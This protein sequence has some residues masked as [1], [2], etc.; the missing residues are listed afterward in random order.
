MWRGGRR[1]AVATSRRL[2]NAPDT[3]LRDTSSHVDQG[4]ARAPHDLRLRRAG[5]G[6]PARRPPPPGAAQPHA[7]RGLLARRASRTTTSST[8]SRTPSATGWPGWS[9]PRRSPTLDITVGLV[10]DLMVINPFDFFVE[11]YAERCRSPT[12]TSL[13]ADLAPYL[14]PVDER[15]GPRRLRQ[16]LP[17][18]AGRPRRTARRTVDVP[19]R[20]QRRRARRVAYSVRMEPGRAD[21][22][23][24][25]H[26]RRSAPAATRPGCWSRC[27]ASTASPPASSP[28]TSCSSPPTRSPRR[29]Q[30]PGPRLH[31]PARLGRGL[32]ARCRLGRH[33][34]D[35]APLR[36][37]GPHPALRD[38]R[39]RA[40]PPRSRAPPSP[41]EVTFSFHN[42]VTRVHEDP[43]VTK[44]YTDDQWAR[45]DALGEAVDQRLADGD[46]RLTMGGEPTFVSLD[47]TD[48]RAVEHR[49][50]RPG[51]ARPWPP[52][53]PS[54]CARPT[55]R[56]G[57][58]T[59]ARASGTPASPCPAG[60]I[61]LQWRTDGVPL[62]RAR[63]SSPTRGARAATRRRPPATPRPSPP[64]SRS[65]LGLP[66][67][68]RPPGVRGP[69]RRR[70]PP[71][72]A[73]RRARPPTRTP[74]RST[75]HGLG[76]RWTR[77]QVA[78][79]H[80]LGAAARHQHGRPGRLGQ[81]AVAL[82]PRPARAGAGHRPAG[83]RLP[84]DSVAWKE[85]G[86]G[87]A[88]VP[89]GR[90]PRWSRRARR[91]A[92]STRGRGHHRAGVRGPRR[93]TSTSS[94]RP[95][96]Q[97]DDYAALLSS[98]SAAARTVGRP[99][100]LEGYGPP[101]DP[102]LTQLIVTPDPGVIEVNV[103]PTRSWAELRELTTTLYDEARQA[104]P[105]DR[106]VRPRRPP[107]R[108]RRRQ[109]PHPRRPPRRSTRPL[110]RRPDL[111]V[112]LLTYWQ[113]HPSPVLPVLRPLHRP[114]SQAPRFDEGRPE[115]LYEMEIA[116]AEIDRLAAQASGPH[117]TGEGPRPWLVDR[118]LRHL[119]TDLTGNTHRAE[120]CIDKLYSP[121]S[122][123]GRLGLLELRGFEM[124]PHPQM[125]LVQALLV[126]ASSRCSGTQPFA[127]P[128]VRWGTEL[129]EDF[130]LPAGRDSDIAAGGRR[131]ARPRHRL[132][133][134]VA[135]P[136]HGVPLP[137]HR[138]AR[139]IGRG[140]EL[141][142]RQAIEPW[143]V[144]GE[145]ATAGGTARYVDSSVER[146]QVPVAGLDP[147]RHLV[148]CNGVPVPLTPTGA[149]GRA[150]RRRAL[151]RL[152]AA[153]GAA[154]HHRGARPAALRR[155]RPRRGARWAVR[156]T[157][158]ST[159]AAGPTTHPPVNAAEAEARRASRFEARGHTA[160][161]ARRRRPAR[162]R[163]RRR[164]LTRRATPHTLDLRRVPCRRHR[165]PADCG[166]TATSP[167]E[168]LGPVSDARALPRCPR[169]RASAAAHAAEAT[170]APACD[171]AVGAATAPSGL[172]WKGLAEVAVRPH[173]P[174]TSRRVDADITR[175]PRR[176]RR[177]LQ[178]GRA[179]GPGPGA[180]TRCRSCSRPTSGPPL[181]VA[182]AQR[183][184]LLNAVL[185][186]LYGAARLLSRGAGAARRRARSPRLP[187]GVARASMHRPAPAAGR[188]HRPRPRRR[189]ALARPRPTG[190]RPRP[191]SATPWRTAGSCRG[192]C[193]SS[194]AR[195]D[196]HRLAPFFSRAPLRRCSQSAPGDLDDPRVVVLIARPASARPP[197]TRPF[198]ASALGFPLVQGGDLVVRDGRVWMRGL[199]RLEPRRRHP[200]PGRRAVVR[201]PRAARPTPS[202][203]SPGWSRRA[204]RAR[205][206]RQRARL[207]RAGEPG[208]AALPARALRGAARRAA[209][210][211]AR[212][213]PGGAATPRAARTCS[214]TSTSR[215]ASGAPG[216]RPAD[217]LRRHSARRASCGAIAGRSR[218]ATSGRSCCRSRSA[219]LAATASAAECDRRAR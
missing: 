29:P 114:T 87:R 162:G 188:R 193:P 84:L 165:G 56:A 163:G 144:L 214:T 157:T 80:R 93:P 147:H 138:H 13:A 69:A 62:W 158:S 64:R 24:D 32:P 209:A 172:P 174:T 178:P 110:L 142:L 137:A 167:P 183:A 71:R 53:S 4:R 203:A 207:R 76:R 208:P 40:A 190:P 134:G 217:A 127:A 57:S 78:T 148:T 175:A 46:V 180:S 58:S 196:L 25:A 143:H 47:D 210:A 164:R 216:R 131:P 36:R 185:A 117:G 116:F 132:R 118:A 215:A 51:E 12:S 77:P 42:E 43:R 125:A 37:R 173:R 8:G 19:R 109:P 20:A 145:E 33:G 41:C 5:H 101:P 75:T 171:E 218:T 189:R 200:A 128:L 7:H 176:R 191:G 107:H 135:R 141:E 90:A 140:H 120:F 211:A 170:A 123:R 88:V 91:H 213:R 179:S 111:L 201:P 199:G 195:P 54:G 184:E 154:P 219:H 72:C 89:R 102:R 156:P 30:R 122:S 27:C 212:S 21:P 92:W 50:R 16:S 106:E 28:A 17:R 39:T 97:L 14:R 151:P 3:A 150:L 15:P 6:G 194:T 168:S 197:S 155:R 67:E 115:A 66:A 9:S 81:P 99:V 52:R 159:P 45:I 130:L 166:A 95:T 74:R 31:R 177:H 161:R 136:V 198:I 149:A 65:V 152:A 1:T 94:S 73:S 86:P 104:R 192:S 22:R 98:S 121:D 83:L 55:P 68:Q 160:G 146:V 79:A 113:R 70:S 44:P 26:P 202:S 100:V 48:H 182:L 34:P 187:A 186:D 18:A 49:R 112:S 129:H 60:S 119:L 103:Q 96:E 204:A 23:R 10:A 11:E 63:R 205:P 133:G 82:P 59:A 206:R 126:R 124:P 181:E 105:D 108:H 139:R 38:A 153:V 85:P 2:G 169:G 35:L 61:A